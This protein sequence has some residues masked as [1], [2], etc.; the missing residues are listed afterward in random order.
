MSYIIFCKPTC[1]F[2][3]EAVKLLEEKEKNFKIVN[4]QEDQQQILEE[5]KDAMEY[6]T[7]P[8]IFLRSG[9]AIEFV[10]GFTDLEKHLEDA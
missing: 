2:C 6:P 9:Q 3:T 5:V 1:P 4:F 10:G 7:V 8:M